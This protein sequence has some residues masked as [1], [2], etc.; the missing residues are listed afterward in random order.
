MRKEAMFEERNPVLEF[1]GNLF[2]GK[3]RNDRVD[4]SA[5]SAPR[6]RVEARNVSTIAEAVTEGG[7]GEEEMMWA[8]NN[9]EKASKMLRGGVYYFF[10]GT[11]GADGVYSLTKDGRG[12]RSHKHMDTSFHWKPATD[13]IVRSV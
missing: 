7:A 1:F 10:P 6:L 13:R 2:R 9:P 4:F 5:E 11:L 12:Y 3:P 8:K